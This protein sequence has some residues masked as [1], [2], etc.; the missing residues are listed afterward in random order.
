MKQMVHY[1]GI[2]WNHH[3][4]VAG[5]VGWIVAVTAC[6]ILGHSKEGK[7][8]ERGSLLVHTYITVTAGSQSVGESVKSAWQDAIS[9]HSGS[10]ARRQGAVS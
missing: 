3:G 4:Q 7:R 6:C 9:C 5:R 10:S 8:P 2:L 1:T